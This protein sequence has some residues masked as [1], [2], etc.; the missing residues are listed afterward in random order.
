MKEVT[1]FYVVRDTQNPDEILDFLVAPTD[2]LLIR[3]SLPRLNRIS[4]LKDLEFYHMAT[5]NRTTGVV[6][7][8]EPRLVPL[9]SYKFPER[10]ANNPPPS[11]EDMRRAKQ[12]F[13]QTIQD[14]LK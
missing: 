8:V 14:V 13:A 3:N 12:L 11:A 9:D 1:N 6:T 10:P 4:A 2:G 7:P 5:I